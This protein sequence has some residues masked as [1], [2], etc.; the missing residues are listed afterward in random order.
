MKIARDLDIKS[1]V[2]AYLTK[3]VGNVTPRGAQVAQ[4]IGCTSDEYHAA[5]TWL[6][7]NGKIAVEGVGYGRVVH[8]IGVGKTVALS[9]HRA[10]RDAVV[11]PPKF[12]P[13]RAESYAC[14]RCG[15]RNCSDHSAGFLTTSARVPAW[16]AYA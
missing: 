13:V 10:E 14:P 11:P 2:L 15:A 8:V 4:D 3:R 12:E 9:N 5:C 16:R 6:K 1:R 7:R